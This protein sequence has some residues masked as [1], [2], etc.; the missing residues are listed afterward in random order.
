MLVG[1][2]IFFAQKQSSYTNEEEDDNYNDTQMVDETSDNY[3]RINKHNQHGR[4]PNS[5][6]QV[7]FFLLPLFY[8]F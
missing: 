6:D 2:F 1:L 4:D 3:D 8:T 7:C 5:S